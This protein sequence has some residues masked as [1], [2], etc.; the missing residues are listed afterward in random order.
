MHR[1]ARRGMH[2]RTGAV[3]LSAIAVCARRRSILIRYPDDAAASLGV[4]RRRYHRDVEVLFARAE[5][6]IG[7][8]RARGDGED[9]QEPA[10]RRDFQDPGTEKLRDIEI[11]FA[12]EFE[13]VGAG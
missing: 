12:V 6:D 10:V 1:I 13:T 9:M 2:A 4:V 8:R 11:A 5:S 7:R 3:P